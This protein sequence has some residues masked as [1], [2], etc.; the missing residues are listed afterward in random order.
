[1]IVGRWRYEIYEA[2]FSSALAACGVEVVPCKL[3]QFFQ[4]GLSSFRSAIPILD[5]MRGRLNEYILS[6]AYKYQPEWILFWRPTHIIPKTLKTIADFGIKTVSFNND[7]PFGPQVHGNVPWH[8]HF[9]WHWYI[10]C[11][12][13]FD[14]NFFYRRV[15]CD[16]ALVKGARHADVMLPYFIPEKDR[17]VELN[18]S[19]RSKYVADVAFVGHYEPDGREKS[20]HALVNA[21][22][23][24][25]I[26]GGH[27]WSRKLL[28]DLYDKLQPIVPA[29]GDDYAKALCGAKVCL[30]FLSKLNRDTYTRRCF[31]IP[32]CGRVMLAERTDDLMQMFKEDEEACF[33]STVDELVNKVNWLLENSEIRER[34]AKAGQ[35]RVWTDGHDVNSRAQ[36]F[37][38]KLNLTTI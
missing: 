38:T 6:C 13:A 17:P 10:K 7:D 35:R 33:F 9:L 19:D 26:W 29:E 5:F 22:V 2:S 12:P 18:A 1:M 8:H 37:I 3:D 11:L 23:N 24:L 30:A 21:G 32:A 14:R 31:E 25:K 15:N 16:E 20:V 27:Y 4:G 34:I 28:G 36:E